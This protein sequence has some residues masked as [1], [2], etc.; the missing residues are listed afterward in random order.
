VIQFTLGFFEGSTLI[1]DDDLR[2]C[3]FVIGDVIIQNSKQIVNSTLEL[4][5]IETLRLAN[6]IAFHTHDLVF[7]C[8]DGGLQGYNAFLEMY[9]VYTDPR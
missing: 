9:E 4:R 3:E 6:D 2:L 8:Y 7:G 1:E 5:L